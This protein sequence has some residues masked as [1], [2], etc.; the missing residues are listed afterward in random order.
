MHEHD[1][2]LI[3]ALADG[4]LADEAEARALVDACDVCRAEYRSQADVL[5]WIASAPRAEMTEPEKAALHR[6]LWTEL[7]RDPARTASVPWWQR[8]SYVAAGLFVVVGLAGVLNGVIGSGESGG[9]T[10]ESP[11]DLDLADRGDEAAPFLAEDNGSDGAGE[12]AATT[13]AAAEQA[14]TVPFPELADQVRASRETDPGTGTTSPDATVTE[15]L[16]RVG[17]DDHIVVAE[18]ELD[19]V[20]L[21]VMARDEAEGTVTFVAPDECEIAFVDR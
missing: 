15:C 17:L 20:Y 2:D 18:L 9:S 13:T 12:S 5:A 11:V 4:S 19:R 21:A 6:D 3:A 1:L 7:R 14:V 16:E 8:W 10:A